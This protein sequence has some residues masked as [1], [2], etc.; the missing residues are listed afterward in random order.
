MT[1][2][3]TRGNSIHIRIDFIEG[4]MDFFGIYVHGVYTIDTEDDRYNSSAFCLMTTKRKILFARPNKYPIRVSLITSN[5]FY[6]DTRDAAD[7]LKEVLRHIPKA[8]HYITVFRKFLIEL[9][10]INADI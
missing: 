5:E 6:A 4:K 3:D 9:Y 10:R 2:R 7:R 1:F 8:T